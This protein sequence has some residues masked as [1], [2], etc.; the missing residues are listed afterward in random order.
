LRYRAFAIYWVSILPLVAMS[1]VEPL[2]LTNRRTFIRGTFSLTCLSE[3]LCNFWFRGFQSNLLAVCVRAGAIIGRNSKPLWLGLRPKPISQCVQPYD[4]ICGVV[5]WVLMVRAQIFSP[6]AITADNLKG[7]SYRVWS[8]IGWNKRHWV[9]TASDHIHDHVW[10]VN[11]PALG[12][13]FPQHT[14]SGI[15]RCVAMLHCI[16]LIPL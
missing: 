9:P 1:Q 14:S 8:R 3:Q 15:V 6:A 2:F 11:G 4:I 7:L 12:L 5:Y 13:C 10:R 16:P